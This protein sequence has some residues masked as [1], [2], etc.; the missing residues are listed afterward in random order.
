[1][2]H[3][4]FKLFIYLHLLIIFSIFL[5]ITFYKQKKEENKFEKSYSKKYNVL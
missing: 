4:Y 5:F 2:F 1:M 3:I